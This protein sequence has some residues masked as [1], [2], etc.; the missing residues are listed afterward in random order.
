MLTKQCVIFLLSDPE[1]ESQWF[2]Q[3]AVF[4]SLALHAVKVFL[5]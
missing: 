2:L 1:K 3:T 4:S 5:D